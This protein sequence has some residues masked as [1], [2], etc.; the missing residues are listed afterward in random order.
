MILTCL[1]EDPLQAWFKDE[2]SNNDYSVKIQMVGR[3][4][5][6]ACCGMKP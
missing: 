2:T 5:H 4:D 1:A 6:S 3:R